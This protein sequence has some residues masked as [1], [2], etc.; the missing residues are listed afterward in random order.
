MLENLKKLREEAGVTQKQLADVIGVSQQS[1]NKY[2]NHNIEPDIETLIRIADYFNTSVDFIIGHTD[3][4]RRVSK[5]EAYELSCDEAF[6][7][8]SYRKMT[9]RQRKSI[10]LIAENYTEK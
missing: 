2:E 3:L 7:I 8:D 6:I 1:V 9:P 10:D 4:R 5:V